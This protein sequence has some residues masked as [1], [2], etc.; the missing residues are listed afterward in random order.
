[1]CIGFSGTSQFIVR[2]LFW[3]PVLKHTHQQYK[4]TLPIRIHCGF[5]LRANLVDFNVVLFLY[6]KSESLFWYTRWDLEN[7]LIC[8]IYHSIKIVNYHCLYYVKYIL[9]YAK[10]SAHLFFANV[11]V[12]SKFWSRSGLLSM[13]GGYTNN[14]LHR[15][16]QVQMLRTL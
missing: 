12:R 15:F 7:G 8:K 13:S 2:N 11:Q 9:R 1:M 6:S 3:L 10:L 16:I 4:L 14:S 5:G